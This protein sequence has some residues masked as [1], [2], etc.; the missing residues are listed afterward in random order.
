MRLKYT[1]MCKECNMENYI[2]KK[3][4]TEHPDKVEVIKYCPR[5][6]KRTTHI[7]KNK[8]NK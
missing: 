7:E 6:D 5:C 8:K 4:K 2:D 1:L 3:N